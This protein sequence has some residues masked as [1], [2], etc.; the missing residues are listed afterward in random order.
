MGGHHPD[1]IR[2]I[3]GIPVAVEVE[4][5]RKSSS[6]LEAILSLHAL[7]RRQEKTG[8]VLYVV[9]SP[10]GVQRVQHLAERQGLTRG[11]GGL[12]LRTVD[13][14]REALRTLSSA[15]LARERAA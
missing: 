2:V 8:G 9:D 3:E 1:L 10:R 15:A 5:Q 13:E 4:L 11:V 6:R 7:W 12:G 14:V